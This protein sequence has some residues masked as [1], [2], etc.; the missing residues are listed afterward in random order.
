MPLRHGSRGTVAAGAACGAS[1]RVSTTQAT[2]DRS[3]THEIAISAPRQPPTS[4][5]AS[6]TASAA[7]PVEPIWIPVV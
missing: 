5:P 6:G 4:Q 7:A 1:P 2:S 3:A